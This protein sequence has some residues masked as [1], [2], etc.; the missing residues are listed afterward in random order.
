MIPKEL[1]DVVL[2]FESGYTEDNA[3][4]DTPAAIRAAM[5]SAL[6]AVP[7]SWYVRPQ[8]VRERAAENDRLGIWA[9]NRWDRFTNQSPTHECIFHALV[10]VMEACRAK[11][12]SSSFPALEVD[13]RLPASER[14]NIVWLSV[15]SGY[16]EANP[17]QWGGSSLRDAIS[18]AVERGLLPDVIQPREYGFKHTMWGTA[19]KGTLNQSTG[20][21]PGWSGG[22]FKQH[23]KG[24]ANENWRETARWFRAVEAV[25]CS[26]EEEYDSVLINGGAWGIARNGHSVPVGRIVFD[27]GR[28]LYRYKDSYNV[29]RYDSRPYM[30]GAYS[31]LSMTAPDDWTKP[32][33]A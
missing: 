29:Y 30:S 23:P 1:I 6:T 10:A 20:P 9:E 3:R 7:Q 14:F 21:W 25:T 19:G 28:K 16:A 31:I 26:S 13:K 17:G 15:V 33:G 5:G 11:Q 24:W 32:A 12:L 22:T 27:D 8:D 4:A 18:I 2:P